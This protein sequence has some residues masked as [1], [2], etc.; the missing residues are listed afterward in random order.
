M[1]VLMS[2]E[3]TSGKARSLTPEVF[4]SLLLWF[5]SDNNRAAQMY[6]DAR[7]KLASLFVRKGCAHPEELADRTLDRVAVI[8]HDDSTK[9]PNVMALCCGV[10]RRVW[11][12]YC[13]EHAS[14][15]LDTE[16]LA[17]RVEFSNDFTDQEEKCLESC[18][19]AL[20]P[21]D[22]TLITEYHRFQGSQ[23]IEVRKR[24]ANEHGGLNKVRIL[25]YRIRVKL[26]HCVGVCTQRLGEDLGGKGI[27]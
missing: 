5:S 15:G 21:R 20:S 27:A 17:A 1:I 16:G 11:L 13:R 22:R 24:L 7:R 23:K 9:Y 10:A 14:T 6:L 2:M 4:A 19:D 3:S 12:E 25:A 26:Q 18:L 8:V